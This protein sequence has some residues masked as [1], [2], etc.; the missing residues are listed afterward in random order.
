MKVEPLPAVA[1]VALDIESGL[2][3]ACPFKEVT[4]DVACSDS[5]ILE[6]RSMCRRGQ[7]YAIA[8]VL[9]SGVQGGESPMAMNIWISVSVIVIVYAIYSI[10]YALSNA[11]SLTR[12]Y[13]AVLILNNFSYLVS[14]VIALIRVYLLRY[15]RRHAAHYAMFIGAIW[16]GFTGIIA[17][18]LFIFVESLTKSN[19]I[20]IGVDLFA[21]AFNIAKGCMAIGFGASTLA[22]NYSTASERMIYGCIFGV[23]YCC[24]WLVSVILEPDEAYS[25]DLVIVFI[26]I[27]V[28]VTL[29]LIYFRLRSMRAADRIVADDRERYDAEWMRLTEAKSFRSKLDRLEAALVRAREVHAEPKS[30]R[31]RMLKKLE[32]V[33]VISGSKKPRQFVDDLAVLLAQAAALNTHFQGIIAARAGCGVHRPGSVKSRGRAI[34]K[35]YRS[36]GGDA[37]R[38]VDL[39]RT[40]IVFDDIDDVIAFVEALR[41]DPAL[42]V[43]GSKNGLSCTVDSR[44]S[45]GYRNV[46]LS[47][48]VVDSLAFSQGLDVHICELQLGIAPIEKLRNEKGHANYIKW[49]DINAQ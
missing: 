17:H 39:V 43:V 26:L 25:K 1:E 45:A 2:P 30:V 18:V 10:S 49:R 44:E 4:L 13:V 15:R 33:Q 35:L 28:L 42:A 19:P 8:T 3:P 21:N 11:R 14:C 22:G 47:V 34:E 40:I 38:L 24:G 20:T 46:N 27:W 48:I 29:S 12:G 5:R 9:R 31:A 6:L 7:E 32:Q 36:Y 37:S 23:F 16:F 41:D